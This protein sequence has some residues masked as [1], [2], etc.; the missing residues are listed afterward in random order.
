MIRCTMQLWQN[1]LHMISEV[2]WIFQASFSVNAS[3]I[4]FSDRSLQLQ[5]DKNTISV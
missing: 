1:S 2:I 4:I 3:I 5:S